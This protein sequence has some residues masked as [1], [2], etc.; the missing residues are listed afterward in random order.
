MPFS[1]RQEAPCAAPALPVYCTNVRLQE[2]S[3]R[4]DWARPAVPLIGGVSLLTARFS[5]HHYARHS[6]DA[7]V[8]AVVD[9]GAQQFTYRGQLCVAAAGDVVILAP[10]EAHDGRPYRDG[11]YLYRTLHIEPQLLADDWGVLPE[12]P[13]AILQD[14]A[15]RHRLA[16][17]CAILDG[18]DWTVE[19]ARDRFDTVIDWLR[20]RHGGR[21]QAIRPSPRA[22]RALAEAARRFL[23]TMDCADRATIEEVGRRL[24][25][26][27]SHLSR[28]YT[29]TY[30][31]PPHAWL[32]QRRLGHA[33]KLMRQGVPLAEVAVGAGFV[34][35]SHFTRRFKAVHG[36]TPAQ[37]AATLAAARS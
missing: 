3:Q 11:A 12:F 23:A 7:Y 31:L 34:D 32:L 29:R 16:G 37:A 9:Q 2:T 5:R 35:Q 13:A 14:R 1:F 15:L 4:N 26:T 21:S 30:G 6:H 25:V 28:A 17:L 10:G 22:E 33:L 24:G 20:S 36:I 18:S 8:L 19:E 27:R